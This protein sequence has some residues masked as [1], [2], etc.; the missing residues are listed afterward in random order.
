MISSKFSVFT[1]T[2]LVLQ[3]EERRMRKRTEETWQSSDSISPVGERRV[4]ADG[5]NLQNYRI[6]GFCVTEKVGILKI[7]GK[8]F[9]RNGHILNGGKDN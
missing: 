8:F 3:S 1:K 2:T 5:R 4:A 7:G 6:G 9:H